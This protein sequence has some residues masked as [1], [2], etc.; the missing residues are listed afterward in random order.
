MVNAGFFPST[1][2]LQLQRT[3]FFFMEMDSRNGCL[4]TISHVKVWNG[5]FIIQ[6][7]GY[8]HF[9]RCFGYQVTGGIHG[10]LKLT[11]IAPENGPKPKRKRWYSNPPFSGGESHVSFRGDIIFE[12]VLVAEI[13]F[14][15]WILYW[16]SLIDWL[17]SA[18]SGPRGSH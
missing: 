17:V 12:C 9:L 13:H 2:G 11:G 1:V 14:N 16:I 5:W 8:N 7:I 10:T 6:L 15:G 18:L 3:V 4:T